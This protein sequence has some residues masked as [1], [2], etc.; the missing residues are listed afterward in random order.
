MLSKL[1]NIGYSKSLNFEEEIK[2]GLLNAF[3]FIFLS[4]ALFFVIYNVFY[5][6]Q[7]TLA[8]ISLIIPSIVWFQYKQK[9]Y[10]ARV[11]FFVLAHAIIF[12]TS[13]FLNPGKRIEY[14]YLV[15]IM[16]LMILA[17]KA[18][19]TYLLV[20]LDVMLFFVPQAL[21]NVYPSE[22][23]PY[24]NSIVLTIST[25]W[26]LQSFI[27]IQK[28]YRAKLNSQNN[29]LAILNK[30]KNDL[31][32]IVAHDLKTP[33]AQIKGL[34]SILEFEGS[35][36][37]KEQVELIDKIKGVTDDQHKQISSFLDVKALEEKVDQITYKKF[38]VVANI[39]QMIAEMS[40]LSNSKNI[41]VTEQYAANTI[42]VYG[43]EE[44]WCKIISNLYSNAIKYSH[45]NS[46]ISLR[47]ELVNDQLLFVIKDE[48]Q[49]FKK[50]D[51]EQVFTKNRVLSAKPTL[52]ESASGVGLYI[53]KKYVDMMDGKIWLESEEGKGAAFFVKL[54]TEI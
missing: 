20:F 2:V 5:T 25:V 26:V 48:G 45:A 17:R 38:D 12:S 28:Q 40:T 31:M 53:V 4:L 32:S 37:N 27:K 43:S 7:Y 1:F 35:Q 23:F 34:I 39:K 11:I 54:P 29:K 13:V 8:I 42:D 22:S 19:W 14:F 10:L 30:E 46:A 51:L 50:E 3:S 41:I 36:L 6:R 21:F 24:A 33:L 18:I 16:L 9:Y 52:G 49:G 44:G 47:I 15:I